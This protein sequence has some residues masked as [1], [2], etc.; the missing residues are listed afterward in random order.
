MNRSR[1][2]ALFGICLLFVLAGLWIALVGDTL[3][4]LGCAVMFGGGLAIFGLQI[5]DSYR[6]QEAMI[7]D[8]EVRLPGSVVIREAPLRARMAFAVTF[9][10]GL[11]ALLV[12]IDRQPLMLVLG[13]GLCLTAVALPFFKAR[14]YLTSTIMFCPDG[15]HMTERRRSYVIP[16]DQ[17]VE[18]R[19]GEWNGNLLVYLWPADLE[20]IVNSVEPAEQKESLRKALLQS[21]AWIGAPL[22]IWPNR[23][24][25]QGDFLL[26]GLHRYVSTPQLRDELR[27]HSVLPHAQ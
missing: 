4:G 24:G 26:R 23:F 13:A 25:M 19:S 16:F 6:E 8:G 15:I 9:C 1:L 22:T 2:L 5:V 18:M 10:F 14:G 27:P 12:G 21:E 7:T 17:I 20:V 11:G 3:L